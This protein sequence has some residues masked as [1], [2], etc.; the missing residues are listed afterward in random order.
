MS[1]A[2]LDGAGLQP[3]DTMFLSA[4][5][6]LHFHLGYFDKVHLLHLGVTNLPCTTTVSDLQIWCI[7]RDAGDWKDC[8]IKSSY[9]S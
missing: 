2:K 8:G 4:C 1:A 5:A 3:T 7:R 9:V 6:V